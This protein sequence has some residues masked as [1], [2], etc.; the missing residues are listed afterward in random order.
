M[1]PVG[2]T[3]DINYLNDVFGEPKLKQNQPISINQPKKK[4]NQT[5]EYTTLFL[6]F[7]K[8]DI[9]GNNEL[10]VYQI[11]DAI[12]GFIPG[13]TIGKQN[14][15]LTEAQI[16]E[17]FNERFIDK[18]NKIP[19][20][21]FFE[22][23]EYLKT[24]DEDLNKFKGQ[25]IF[26]TYDYVISKEKFMPYNTIYEFPSSEEQLTKS[27]ISE[28]DNQ[29]FG[30][31]TMI[32]RKEFKFE[33]INPQTEKDF[34]DSDKYKNYSQ[35]FGETLESND[36]IT[37]NQLDLDVKMVDIEGNVNRREFNPTF[38]DFYNPFYSSS[39]LTR[40]ASQDLS[41]LYV[42]KRTSFVLHYYLTGGLE[43]VFST[44]SIYDAKNKRKIITDHWVE[45]QE[46]LPKVNEEQPHPF[47]V[48]LWP[49][50]IENGDLY[51]IIK[52]YKYAD[53]DIEQVRDMYEKGLTD[54]KKRKYKPKIPS[55][56]D[57]H[58]FQLLMVGCLPVKEQFCDK[59]GQ[60]FVTKFY[61]GD[62]ETEKKL[63]DFIKD[64]ESNKIKEIDENLWTVT[65]YYEML[66]EWKTSKFEL[67]NGLREQYYLEHTVTATESTVSKA[68]VLDDF[69]VAIG[70]ERKKTGLI[71]KVSLRESDANISDESL[72]LKVFYPDIINR[73]KNGDVKLESCGH[74]SFSHLKVGQFMTEILAELP[75]PLK[76][77]HHLLFTITDLSVDDNSSSA[78]PIYAVLPLLSKSPIGKYSPP[79]YSL[80]IS[81]GI[82]SQI[83]ILKNPSKNY[84]SKA[85][86]YE[87]SKMYVKVKT[88]LQSTVYPTTKETH[89]LINGLLLFKQ[90]KSQPN[91]DFYNLA[92]QIPEEDAVHFL[93]IIMNGLLSVSPIKANA[94][95]EIVKKVSNFEKTR[96]TKIQGNE[97][98][99]LEHP[100]LSK[101]LFY[102]FQ[103][104][105][106]T[107]NEVLLSLNVLLSTISNDVVD[108]KPQYS[109]DLFEHIW[110]FFEVI[111]KSLVLHLNSRELLHS[112]KRG[113][114][115]L[116]DTIGETKIKNPLKG[117]KKFFVQLFHHTFSN[118]IR[119]CVINKFYVNVMKANKA[120]AIF[121][122]DL[123]RIYSRGD[124]FQAIE[125]HIKQVSN[126]YLDSNKNEK[127]EPNTV[128]MTILYILR[129]DFLNSI[130]HF[131][132]FD[133]L[134]LPDNL[135][136]TDI[137]CLGDTLLE[138]YFPTYFI[139][140]Q[141]VLMALK[142]H[143]IA[144]NLFPLVFRL[145]DEDLS[146]K[147]WANE[148]CRIDIE[149]KSGIENTELLYMF[150]SRLKII[151]DIIRRSLM[152]LSKYPVPILKNTEKE[153]ERIFTE[154]SEFL[155]KPVETTDK[156][157]EPK[158]GITRHRRQ[159]DAQIVDKK[160]D[161]LKKLVALYPKKKHVVP[162]GLADKMNFLQKYLVYENAI[163]S[164]DLLEIIYET[165]VSVENAAEESENESKSALTDVE[166]VINN[167]LFNCPMNKLYAEQ[168]FGFIKKLLG[169]YKSF[170]LQNR[171]D[172]S[173]QLLKNIIRMCS[174]EYDPIV[175]EYALQCLYIFAKTNFVCDLEISRTS[176]HII[177]ALSELQTEINNFD[178]FQTTIDH[179]LALPQIDFDSS[180]K[181]I[182][183]MIK[184][185]SV[186]GMNNIKYLMK[187]QQLQL[188]LDLGDTDAF[189][190]FLCDVIQIRLDIIKPLT[191]ME[192]S[193]ING[194]TSLQLNVFGFI[195][196]YLRI[197]ELDT[198][199]IKQQ[200]EEKYR[201]SCFF[202]YLQ[203]R[204]LEVDSKVKELK[205]YLDKVQNDASNKKKE[206]SELE[207]LF[208]QSKESSIKTLQWVVQVITSTE[209]ESGFKEITT[210]DLTSERLRELR[211]MRENDEVRIKKEITER[212][213]QFR[214][215][216]N[217]HQRNP[218]FPIDEAQFVGLLEKVQELFEK[219][220]EC[221]KQAIEQLSKY[222]ELKE[223]IEDIH[224]SVT[225]NL[226]DQ[227]ISD[228]YT[229]VT[230]QEFGRVKDKF[231]QRDD[232][233]ER[234]ERLVVSATKPWGLR[235]YYWKEILPLSV[236]ITTKINE[237][238]NKVMINE[239]KMGVLKQW[240]KQE[241]KY[242][243]DII[244]MFEWTKT[245]ELIIKQRNEK[246]NEYSCWFSKIADDC[247]KDKDFI[248][249]LQRLIKE[250]GS[251]LRSVIESYYIESK[252][253]SFRRRNTRISVALP[254]GEQLNMNYSRMS[255]D[256]TADDSESTMSYS[257]AEPFGDVFLGK[258]ENI[259]GECLE[260]IDECAQIFAEQKNTENGYDEQ[261]KTYA[262]NIVELGKMK[263]EF[264]E[265]KV[266]FSY[267][268]K[269][270]TMYH[271]IIKAEESKIPRLNCY[272]DYQKQP[273]TIHDIT[274]TTTEKKS[275]QR[276]SQVTVVTN[277]MDSLYFLDDNNNF[278]LEAFL[279]VNQHK[280]EL[281]KKCV[282]NMTEEMT[283]M[284]KKLSELGE[285]SNK[286]QDPEFIIQKYY[287]STKV[288]EHNPQLHLTWFSK[289]AEENRKVENSNFVEA[290][291]CE[292]HMVHYIYHHIPN[293]SCELSTTL[294]TDL[295][296]DFLSS[297]RPTDLQTNNN[298]SFETMINHVEQG[299][300]DFE[301]SHL[302][303]YAL[304]LCN[305]ML[306][307]YQQIRD[308]KSFPINTGV[309]KYDGYFYNVQFIGDVFSKFSP[310]N[311]STKAT[312]FIQKNIT[313]NP[314]KNY[315][316]INIVYP[317]I[318]KEPIREHKTLLTN[319][320]VFVQEEE[321][322]TTLDVS[323]RQKTRFLYTTELSMP[324]GLKRQIVV[325]TNVIDLS[326]I[327]NITDD[328]SIHDETAHL[329]VIQE[330][331]SNLLDESDRGSVFDATEKFLAEDIFPN[332]D[333]SDVAEL[334]TILQRV[335]EMVGA[336][337][338][339]IRRCVDNDDRKSL[340]R[341][342]DKFKEQVLGLEND[343]NI[344]LEQED[345][346][347]E[348][349]K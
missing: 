140:R 155:N 86:Y 23:Q 15:N 48:Q 250:E 171:V 183:N 259:V 67:Y 22:F 346:F 333:A 238:M 112:P 251:N 270:K 75:F 145:I 99:H 237:I 52:H 117:F 295:C 299:I 304:A 65:I 119:T 267:F 258:C 174:Y 158:M 206:E 60:L 221:I 279:D 324:C 42:E 70:K 278:R 248:T 125:Y 275:K 345:Y 217:K 8:I 305:F 35:S 335:C 347:N 73:D 59:K 118:C 311:V 12:S 178:Q 136:I 339:T 246:P 26:M 39:C 328:L 198:E 1:I 219:K 208:L 322:N 241:R 147:D 197:N 123:F 247:L 302:Y 124:V 6:N 94:I 61:R 175:G 193:L 72:D 200:I 47:I 315:I 19:Q 188:G 46:N 223:E 222:K 163:I 79:F 194:Y 296:E 243:F 50:D 192:A 326:P 291:M 134:S 62:I 269:I 306:P 32:K 137:G 132:Y 116:E 309:E 265:N 232:E 268:Q 254:E 205:S 204:A 274:S 303:N 146:F 113:S 330:R 120:Y 110:F 151:T 308:Y 218:Y 276:K 160:L 212:I 11:R 262:A 109:P 77:K 331:I 126:P 348:D 107:A 214:S 337:L 130:T 114:S 101:Y 289:M 25:K 284:V 294:L 252:R 266:N 161:D 187:I 54:K 100:L 17:L 44:L 111:I 150:P 20:K 224:N 135:K 317:M 349:I 213:E 229:N 210:E 85:E 4:K 195:P 74:T 231:E 149:E 13:V 282:A 159:S 142:K 181:L 321:T 256:S 340:Q 90:E 108:A 273:H 10:D 45:S 89:Q 202:G 103:C 176:N 230:N 264:I 102:Y 36:D 128:V 288:Y 323:K 236:S 244:Q 87:Q 191:E 170:I 30:E 166:F 139:L 51:V 319:T 227:P 144:N 157:I 216:T 38:F 336:G 167:V 293:R 280:Q 169:K 233:I 312:T 185:Y 228:S 5:E 182:F 341:K 199:K 27:Y 2:N 329:K 106:V 40:D 292:L 95:L 127:I 98:D 226:Y 16:K 314:K 83:P 115:Y 225:T 209:K 220:T 281:F 69:E 290:G 283:K 325:K 37:I 235:F 277:E 253:A 313:L 165:T 261:R 18:N 234:M 245:V 207:T 141:Y 64:F 78:K 344:F 84:L 43:K 33:S 92:L 131:P 122:L 148:C 81:N 211:V 338:D 271:S 91:I 82:E 133:K 3:P 177:C 310:H 334:F 179:V 298:C 332:Y 105:D 41:P 286:S 58:K 300:K 154:T 203:K 152:L 29:F 255:N 71:V 240:H 301:Q 239:K 68:E 164:M 93:P 168:L 249:Q 196:N 53:N 257:S 121:L 56:N 7:N 104:S 49:D 327:Q 343:I 287:E 88:I 272:C 80:N 66:D 138:K 57:E 186:R 14:Y 297:N 180:R 173:Y 242:A 162:G 172:F 316:K 9:E 263:D 156:N 342:Y 285:L 201:N 63:Y 34:Y 153:L 31:R 76:P 320:N 143:F 96:Y 184:D 129:L 190:S 97:T 189:L 215:V 28:I 21:D 318:G 24:I 55:A 307:Y 260:Q